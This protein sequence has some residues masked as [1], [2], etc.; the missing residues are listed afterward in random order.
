MRRQH[1]GLVLLGALLL[2]AC[3]GDGD[4]APEASATPQ[5]GGAAAT[6]VLTADELPDGWREASGQQHL[7]VP[8]MCDVVLEPPSLESVETQRFT[9]GPTGPFVIQYSFVSSDEKAT[10]ERIDAFV[11]AAATCT[12]HVVDA[13]AGKVVD[14]TRIDDVAP[15]GDAFA[16]VRGDNPQVEGNTQD[17]VVFRNGPAVTVLQ[18]Y[19]PAGADTLP[20]HTVLEQMAAAIDRKQT[21]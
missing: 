18:S 6:Y 9:R 17:F 21:S 12:E 15:V 14:V 20:D 2:A 7:G 10:T 11:S 13:D 16:A 19:S 1:A 5:P 4:P 8:A 3:S